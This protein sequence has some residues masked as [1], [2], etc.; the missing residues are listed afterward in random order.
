MSGFDLE[1]FLPYLLNRAGAKI[2]DA[3]GRVARRHGVTLQMWR[4]L[5]ALNQRDGQSVSSLA[6]MTSIEISTLS[7]LLGQMQGRGLLQRRRDD[8]DQ[9]SITVHR[10]AAAEAIT[11]TLVPIARAYEARAVIGLDQ[12]QERQLKAMLRRL[13]SNLDAL[14]EIDAPASKKPRSRRRI[15]R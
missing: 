1:N 13:F 12:R 10:T 2:A 6:N 8:G 4:V 15:P 5:A 9:R 3:F 14:D 7:R 11:A